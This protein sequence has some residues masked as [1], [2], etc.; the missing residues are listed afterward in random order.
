MLKNRLAVSLL[1]ITFCTVIQFS[2]LKVYPQQSTT[3]H[4]QTSRGVELY[5]QGDMAGA[6]STLREALKEREDDSRAWHY[7]GLALNRQ[8][9]LREASEA[10]ER[11]IKLLDKSFSEEY[12]SATDEVRDDQLLRLKSLL[13]DEIESRKRSLEINAEEQFPGLGQELLEAAQNRADC[14]DRLTRADAGHMVF[15][16]SDIKTKKARILK[17]PE[18]SYTEQARRERESGEVVLKAVFAADGTVKYIR[19]VK[20]LRYGLT[21][22]AIKAAK[23]IK[24]EPARICDKPVLQFVQIEYYFSNF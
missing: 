2:S 23:K 20:S 4:D 7:L 24:F 8:G 11:A 15:R 6:V 3:A 9:N 21:E 17:K 5:T 19:A 22:Q 12:A 13:N 18:P 14:M 10:F 16:K 1:F